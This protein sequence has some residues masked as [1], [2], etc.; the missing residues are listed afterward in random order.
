MVSILSIPVYT[1]C[2]ELTRFIPTCCYRTISKL[3]ISWPDINQ[4]EMVKT[5]EESK[6]IESPTREEQDLS[7]RMT[8]PRP[9]SSEEAQTGMV[10]STTSEAK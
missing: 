7:Q 1:F 8:S 5:E 2:E 3:D 4:T 10:Q 9:E 6:I